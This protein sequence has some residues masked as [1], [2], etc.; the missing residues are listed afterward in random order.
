MDEDYMEFDRTEIR[1]RVNAGSD[2]DSRQGIADL[3]WIQMYWAALMDLVLFETGD[4][5][6]IEGESTDIRTQYYSRSI[7]AI[8]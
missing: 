3:E 1:S 7:T 5:F 2:V 8:Q 4:T 6:K